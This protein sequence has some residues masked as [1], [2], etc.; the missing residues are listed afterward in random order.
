MIYTV[1]N[2]S[3]I[4]RRVRVCVNGNEVKH[5][6][7]ADTARGVVRYMPQPFRPKKNSDEVFTRLLRGTVTVEDIA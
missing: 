6:I 7:F 1:A 2:T 4:G 5:A 3:A